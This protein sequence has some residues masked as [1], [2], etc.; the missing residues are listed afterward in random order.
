MRRP[1]QVNSIDS[2]RSAQ[3]SWGRNGYVV[4]RVEPETS[5]FTLASSMA[6]HNG[7]F[8]FVLPGLVGL[9]EAR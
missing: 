3:I 6:D 1:G 9:G 7:I 2:M 5:G 8:N 4:A